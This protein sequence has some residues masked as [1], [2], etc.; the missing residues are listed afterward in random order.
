MGVLCQVLR[1]RDR[2]YPQG[3]CGRGVSGAGEL[4]VETT[5]KERGRRELGR[6]ASLSPRYFE[7]SLSHLIGM[8]RVFS[9]FHRQRTASNKPRLE[10]TTPDSQLRAPSTQ[11]SE[12]S[13]TE[14][15]LLW[16]VQ[17]PKL[18]AQ[19]PQRVR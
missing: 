9:P 6:K 11:G 4:A 15:L 14:S 2:A 19:R 18:P 8:Q 1:M 16:G 10:P 13:K 5:P 12:K 3:I 7:L 17:R